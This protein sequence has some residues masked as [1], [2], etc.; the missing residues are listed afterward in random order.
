MDFPLSLRFS[1]FVNNNGGFLDF[2]VQIMQ[3]TVVLVL[4][5][6]LIKHGNSKGPLTLGSKLQKLS[7]GPGCS[8]GG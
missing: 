6:Q 8:K 3:F 7:T 5:R 4:P 1:I 2:S